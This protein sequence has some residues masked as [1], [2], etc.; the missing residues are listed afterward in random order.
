M[1]WAV[2]EGFWPVFWFIGV[3]RSVTWVLGVLWPVRSILKL[4]RFIGR[5]W[6]RGS[7]IRPAIILSL[8]E[9]KSS[10]VVLYLSRIS[11]LV[12]SVWSSLYIVLYKDRVT[13]TY[14]FL[15]THIP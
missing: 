10:L 3:L 14:L 12:H 8:E 6:L 11:F 1:T 13:V 2:A 15:L 4:L 7:G 9:A 5:I